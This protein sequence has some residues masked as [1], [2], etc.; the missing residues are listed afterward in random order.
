MG[1]KFYGYDVCA[2]ICMFVQIGLTN[3]VKICE[4]RVAG[5]KC[6]AIYICATT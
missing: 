2:I 4:T 1:G 5:G 3:V 6:Y